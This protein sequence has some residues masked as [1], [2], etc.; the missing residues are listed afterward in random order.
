MVFARIHDPSECAEEGFAAQSY[1]RL[2]VQVAATLE[3]EEGFHEKAIGVLHD[4]VGRLWMCNGGRARIDL[5][6]RFCKGSGNTHRSAEG[7]A[8]RHAWANRCTSNFTP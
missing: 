3:V 1:L 2:N 4:C 8:F 6:E 5:F 7:D